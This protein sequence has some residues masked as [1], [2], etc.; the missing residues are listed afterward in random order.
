MKLSVKLFPNVL[1]IYIITDDTLNTDLINQK[2]S[3]LSDQLKQRVNII[4]NETV[5]SLKAIISD[6]PN[7]AVLI[8]NRFNVDKNGLPV[9]HTSMLQS[10]ISVARIPVFV[11]HKHDLM[12][13]IIG[14]VLTSGFS[15]GEAAAN[16]V[17]QLLDGA[18]IESLPVEMNLSNKSVIQYSELLRW[19]LKEDSLPIGTKIINRPIEKNKEGFSLITLLLIIL[20]FISV[21]TWL[22]YKYYKL[23]QGQSVLKIQHQRIENIFNVSYDFI[24]ILDLV[25]E[26]K[27]ANRTA[28]EFVGVLRDDIEGEVLWETPWWEND[29]VSKKKLKSAMGQ[30]RVG[31]TARFEC[32]LIDKNQDSYAFDV[33]IQSVKGNG[34][35]ESNEITS[36]IVEARDISGIKAIEEEAEKA[37]KRSNLLLDESPSMLLM[38]NSQGLIVSCNKFGSNLLGY[39]D[40]EL[41]GRNLVTLYSRSFEAEDLKAYLENCVNS[42]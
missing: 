25:G 36:I 20:T 8:F 17:L 34:I 2:I 5:E 24:F 29:E 42:E 32:R 19:G 1:D 26:I 14:G 10:L 35:D 40:G 39:M 21:L 4:S 30:A 27:K 23:N 28:L 12:E 37:N 11:I 18:T 31:K 13:G 9:N 16:K 6:V 22:W 15:Q 38:L 3:M 33:F 41:I 7:D